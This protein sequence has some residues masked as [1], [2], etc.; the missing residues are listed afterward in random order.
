MATE[1]SI[2]NADSITDSLIGVR[3]VIHK[4]A[5]LDQVYVM[6]TDFYESERDRQ[7]NKEM[8]IPNL[9]IGAE[10]QIRRAIIDKNV[11]I[12]QG[13]RIGMDDIDRKDCESATHYVRDGII[14]I[15]K[16][17]I[18]PDGTVI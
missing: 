12:G 4:G 13:C 15:P 5:N 3:S 10:T 18:I 17:S 2:I 7:V 6:G 1:G 14:I 8:K 9:G 16:N 11:K